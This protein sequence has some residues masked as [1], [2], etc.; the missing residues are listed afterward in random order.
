MR[1]LVGQYVRT[2]ASRLCRWTVYHVPLIFTP[3]VLYEGVISGLKLEAFGTTVDMTETLSNGRS[4]YILFQR[5]VALCVGLDPNSEGGDSDLR[6]GDAKIEV[7]A[8]ADADSHSSSK[9]DLFHTSSSST[10]G[11]NNRG[12]E[13]RRLLSAGQYADAL[14]ICSETGYDKNDY[15]LYTNTSHYKTSSPLR[16]VAI[17]KTR[18]LELLSKE[19]PRLINRHDILKCVERKEFLVAS[20]LNL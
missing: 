15:Y 9:H 17:P 2:H 20:S 4:S 13:I 8:F 19:D 14:K 6:L 11:A 18:V 7:K 1:S 12:P 10:F 16:F 5:L 3:Y